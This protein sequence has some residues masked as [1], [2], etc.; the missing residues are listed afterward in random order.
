LGMAAPIVLTLLRMLQGLSVG[1]EYT[2]SIVFMVEH[3]P[4][5]RRGMIG[6]LGGCGAIAG[7]LLGSATAALLSNVLP[8]DGRGVWGWRIP[9]LMGL[10]VGLAGFFLRRRL[11]EAAIPHDATRSPLRETVRHHGW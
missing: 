1:G 3:A 10:V 5:G 2:T 9:F 4:P 6:A 8:A 11:V 7:V